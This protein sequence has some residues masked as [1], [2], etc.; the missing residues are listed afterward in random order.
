[1]DYFLSASGVPSALT[2]FARFQGDTAWTNIGTTPLDLSIYDG[3]RKTIEL[4]FTAGSVAAI[5][6]DQLKL[7]ISRL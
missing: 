4:K 3:Q 7:S 6:H 2:V 1:V 5:E